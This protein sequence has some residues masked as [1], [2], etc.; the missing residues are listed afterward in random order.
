MHC[1]RVLLTGSLQQIAVKHLLK[2]SQ[3]YRRIIENELRWSDHKMAANTNACE[4]RVHDPDTNPLKI[5]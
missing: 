4:S 2:G 1:A 3:R 5:Y